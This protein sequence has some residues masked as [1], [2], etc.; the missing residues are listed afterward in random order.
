M[1]SASVIHAACFAVG[2]VVGGGTV[3]AL[4][5]TSSRKQQHAPTSSS[6]SGAGPSA[7]PNGNVGF[8]AGTT[9]STWGSGSGAVMQ[10]GKN[11]QMQ[12]SPASASTLGSTVLK[13]GHPGAFDYIIRKPRLETNR[14][15]H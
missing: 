3:A 14:L 10:V 1:P 9:A 13:Y 5:S 11:G 12:V 7:K 6:P 8:T 15:I 2:A 4:A